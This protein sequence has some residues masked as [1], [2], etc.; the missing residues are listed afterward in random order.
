[1][2][3]QVLNKKQAL[4]ACFKDSLSFKDM[5]LHISEL[6]ESGLLINGFLTEVAM[7][8]VES[9]KII[10]I[11]NPEKKD[12]FDNS[13]IKE[14]KLSRHRAK[15]FDSN[16]DLNEVLSCLKTIEKDEIKKYKEF[17]KDNI[18]SKLTFLSKD[19]GIT[20]FRGK[21]ITTTHST[22]FDFGPNIGLE[23]KYAFKLGRSVGVYIQTIIDEFNLEECTK[24]IKYTSS[25]DQYEMIDIKSE[26]LYKRSNFQVSNR[27]F[28][29]ALA[30]ILVRLNYT[31]LITNQ[32]FPENDLGLLRLKFINTY[33]ASNSLKKI[34]SL[35]MRNEPS[36]AEKDFFK[37]V[38]NSDDI[39]WLVKQVS[40]RNLFTHY[41]L[42]HNQ[43]KRMPSTFTR[44]DAIEVLSKGV[45]CHNIEEK[46]DRAIENI[47]FNIEVFFNLKANTFWLNK[48]QM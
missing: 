5:L 40:L 42:D 15:L 4:E 23:R 6:P 43:L 47:V 20:K 14:L 8:I 13:L 9:Y 34:Q 39:K 28:A 41:L 44:R 24:S 1:M 19:M 35:I 17:N 33:H 25:I 2:S 22:M 36:A 26:K 27:E 31:K 32:F 30:L 10:S 45:E 11:L 18:A 3:Y 46:V 38:F 48:V 37:S 16:K 21:F 12:C 29:S 7:F